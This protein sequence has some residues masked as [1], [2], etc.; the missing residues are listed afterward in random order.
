VYDLGGGTFDACVLRRAGAGFETL[1][2]EGLDD[3]GGVDLDALVVGQVLASVAP[4]AA[5]AARRLAAPA[6]Q[7]DRRGYRLL[8][9]DS[10]AAKETL[11]RQ[12]QATLFVPVAER[13][14][15]ITRY[16]FEQL[17]RPA[18]DRTV[19][20]TLAA[21]TRSRV[22][23]PEV[24]GVFLVGGSSRVPLVA[25]LL[26]QA[27]GLTPVTLEQP[28]LVVAQGALH[29]AAPTPAG[30]PPAGQ[31]FAGPPSAGSPAGPAFAGSASAGPGLSPAGPG[32]S[33]PYR[34]PGGPVGQRPPVRR[35]GS[36]KKVVVGLLAGFAVLMLIGV[37]IAGYLAHSNTSHRQQTLDLY[38]QV[39][40]PK[41]FSERSGDPKFLHATQIEAVL[42]DTKADGSDPVQ[43]TTDWMSK[44]S[45]NVAPDKST[46]EGY[47]AGSSP[48]TWY[49]EG[50]SPHSVE[51]KLSTSG[52]TYRVDIGIIY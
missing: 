38:H 22:T 10:R 13:D 29:A 7:A 8:L 37:G 24:A 11:S 6:D 23:P 25:D 34:P 1:A 48:K 14:T 18:L 12:P 33:G 30:P 16:E 9:E 4:V 32:P 47:F 44:L 49:P 5:D 19:R 43:A 17:A 2:A 3:F 41:G 42:T 15:R 20:V 27:T 36:G 21:V 45:G 50:F 31:A 46:V 40:K 28:E 52:D 26:R 51:V 39:G 35:K